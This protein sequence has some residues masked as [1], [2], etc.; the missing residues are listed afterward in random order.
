MPAIV[1]LERA[2][3]P[4]VREIYAAG[5]AAG[6]ATFE[7]VVPSWESF[8]ASRLPEHRLVALDTRGDVLGWIACSPV[9]S[10]AVYAGVVEHSVYVAP[11]AQRRGVGHAL[12]AAFVD[13]TEAAGVWTVQSSVFAENEASLRLHAQH[14]FRVVGTRERIGRST[15]GPRAGQWRDTVLIERRSTLAGLA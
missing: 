11:T 10:R 7:S 3:W 15:A 6:D 14:G 13:A 9:S 8:D 4:L 2:H 5:I 12:L 1:P